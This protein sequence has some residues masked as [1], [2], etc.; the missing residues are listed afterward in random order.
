M[1]LSR[2]QRNEEALRRFERATDFPMLLL[3][4][5]FAVLLLIPI[6]A[7]I[8]TETQGTLDALSWLIWAA[9]ALDISIRLVL[10][11]NRRQYA[12]AHWF[13]ILIVAAPFLRP[14]RLLRLIGPIVR[15]AYEVRRLLARRGMIGA[16]TF[17]LVAVAVVG[18]SVAAWRLEASAD[19][20]ITD[21]PDAVWWA[22]TTVTTVG[23][24]DT[25]PVTPEG[26][27]IGALLMLV[28]IGV[29]GVVTASVAAFFVEG[30]DA[31][32]LDEI[33][34]SLRRLEAALA[35]ED[36][37]GDTT[38]DDARDLARLAEHT[39]ESRPT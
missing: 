33:R 36:A 3:A 15:V 20:P 5:L 10:A 25:F 18:S 30:S 38:E 12:L 19:G 35:T 26:R 23:Y 34:A 8:S 24:G 1:S 32:E 39:T 22:L 21:L 31:A 13:D 37:A 27:A 9:F 6:V 4:S 2:Y 17:A 28:G 29:F 11:P 16:L 7:D 14:L